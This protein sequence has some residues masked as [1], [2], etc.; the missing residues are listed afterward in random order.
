MNDDTRYW[1]DLSRVPGIGPARM[2]MLL[3]FFGGAEA[4]WQATAGDLPAAGLDDRTAQALLETRRT[5]DLDAEVE[6]LER[7][8][9]FVLT[10]ESEGYPERLR[11]V[12][13]APP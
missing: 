1:V 7:A 12:D 4:A 10:W 8:G 9:A 3:D 13:D 5:L 2:R 11:E 6:R